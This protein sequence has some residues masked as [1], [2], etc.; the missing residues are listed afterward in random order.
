MFFTSSRDYLANKC[1]VCS[2]EIVELF[3]CPFLWLIVLGRSITHLVQR[4]LLY[5]CERDRS[6]KLSLAF[7]FKRATYMYKLILKDYKL[8]IRNSVFTMGFHIGHEGAIAHLCLCWCPCSVAMKRP[9][10]VWCLRVLRQS[11]P[12]HYI[13]NN[14]SETLF[15]WSV[16]LYVS[17]AL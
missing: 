12:Q 8:S 17:L 2:K 4:P 10:L 13:N 16:L 14:I 3:T 5:L 6:S 15:Y 9:A 7:T 11:G 1:F